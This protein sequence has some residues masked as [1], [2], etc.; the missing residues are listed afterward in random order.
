MEPYLLHQE[1][2]IKLERDEE[3]LQY[4]KYNEKSSKILELNGIALRKLIAE[5]GWS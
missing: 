4:E 1:K 3:L 5:W 2:L